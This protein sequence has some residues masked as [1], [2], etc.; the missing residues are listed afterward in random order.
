MYVEPQLSVFAGLPIHFFGLLTSCLSVLQ[1]A[2]SIA[3]P[4]IV[5]VVDLAYVNLLKLVEEL[6][7]IENLRV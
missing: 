5:L 2:Q 7:V 1:V 4:E 3:D 6:E